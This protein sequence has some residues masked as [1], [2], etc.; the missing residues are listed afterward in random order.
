MIPSSVW[1]TQLEVSPSGLGHGDPGGT[2]KIGP[3]SANSTTIQILG[4]IIFSPVA[5]GS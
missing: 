2:G 1:H 4:T 3:T 5:G